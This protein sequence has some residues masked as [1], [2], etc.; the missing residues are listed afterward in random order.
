MMKKPKGPSADEIAARKAR[1]EQLAREQAKAEQEES[2]ERRKRSSVEAARKR[3][4]LGR[5]SLIGTSELGVKNK[6]GG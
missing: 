5:R 6:L 1:E 3:G 4:S 2:E